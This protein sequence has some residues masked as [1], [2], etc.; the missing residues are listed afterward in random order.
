MDDELAQLKIR[1]SK[2]EVQNKII[3]SLM[4]TILLKVFEVV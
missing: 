4:T 2:I 1:I 3:L